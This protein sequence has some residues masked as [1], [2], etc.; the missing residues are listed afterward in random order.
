M[1][2]GNPLLLQLQRFNQS[3]SGARKAVLFTVF[4]GIM[5]IFIYLI[6][7]A[8]ATAYQYLYSDLEP[9]Q[10]SEITDILGKEAVPFKLVDNGRGILIPAEMVNDV[11]LRMAGKGVNIGKGVGFELF[12]KVNLGTTD[13]VQKMNYKRALQGELARTIAT[14]EEIKGA[15]VHIVLP[16]KSL[17]K[18]DQDQPSASVVVTL[19][20][21][22]ELEKQSI[23]GIKNIV[24]TAVEG[25]SPDNITILDSHGNV[26]AQPKNE[27]GIGSEAETA[28]EFQRNFERKLEAEITTLLERIMGEDK[29]EVKVAAIL[30]LEQQET[31]EEIFDPD[32]VVVRSETVLEEAAKHGES[33]GGVAGA[34]GNNVAGPEDANLAEQSTSDKTRSITNFEINKTVKKSITPAGQIKSLSVSVLVDGTYEETKNSDGTITIKFIP[35]TDEEIS[36]YLEIVKA[37]MG[38]DDKRGDNVSVKCLQFQTKKLP[39]GTEV[40]GIDWTQYLPVIFRAFIILGGILLLI[41]AVMRPVIKW[42]IESAPAEKPPE[43]T[44]ASA[45]ASGNDDLPG[46][47]T[48]QVK[49]KISAEL[50]QMYDAGDQDEGAELEGWQQELEEVLKGYEGRSERAMREDIGNYV[51]ENYSLTASVI[52]TWLRDSLEAAAEER[53]IP[54]A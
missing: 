45:L 32:Q 27:D 7:F 17:F 4:F 35:R 5:G 41:F 23:R 43:F 51:K 54:L 40:A 1:A 2:G 42:V 46:M 14:L 53:R 16:E 36:S 34:Q 22:R 47:S 52:R 6:I 38:F 48:I 24:A 21:G 37:G 33:T 49:P 18:E 39:G 29:V 13:F 9:E 15:R 19:K 31:T 12:D 25:L 26:L 50:K 30:N 11:K 3:M 28:L 10:A 8:D 20:N 44:L